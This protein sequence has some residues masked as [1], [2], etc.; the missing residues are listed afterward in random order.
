MKIFIFLF[1]LL[2]INTV[3]SAENVSII[4]LISNPEKYHNKK[5]IITGYLSL[6]FEGTAVYLHK[7]D[8]THLI[9]K[10]G[11]WFNGSMTKYK[12]YEKKYVS[13]EGVFNKNHKGHMNLW[14]GTIEKINRIWLPPTRKK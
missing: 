11:L 14:Q 5:I 2:S 13:I 9:T 3:H 1:F 4:Q 10:N 8:F 12:K 6:E 7:D